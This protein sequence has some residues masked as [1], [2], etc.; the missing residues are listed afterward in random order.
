MSETPGEDEVLFISER[1]QDEH[2]GRLVSRAD[3]ELLIEKDGTERLCVVLPRFRANEGQIGIPIAT[4]RHYEAHEVNEGRPVW[5]FVI[6]PDGNYRYASLDHLLA[7]QVDYALEEAA[8]TDPFRPD[9][10]QNRG[11][12]F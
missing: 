2:G 1:I 6:L 11:P 3:N 5:F 4:L 12:G 7:T 9:A 8:G 10:P